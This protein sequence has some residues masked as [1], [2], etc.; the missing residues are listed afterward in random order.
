MLD[1]VQQK[2]KNMVK[3]AA[4]KEAEVG[5][6]EQ[7]FEG[8]GNIAEAPKYLRFKGKVKPRETA[9]RD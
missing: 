9:V 1:G 8:L 7:F 4:T 5:E 2:P 6:Q 3:S